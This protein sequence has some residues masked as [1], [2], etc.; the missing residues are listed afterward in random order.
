MILAL[1]GCIGC[2][3]IILKLVCPVLEDFP[4][5]VRIFFHIP[6]VCTKCEL[7]CPNPTA[8]G[9]GVYPGKGEGDFRPRS[10][11]ATDADSTASETDNSTICLGNIHQSFGGLLD[12]WTRHLS[13]ELITTNFLPATGQRLVGDGG[14]P[15]D[16]SRNQ[17]FA[18]FPKELLDF[19]RQYF[20]A[21]HLFVEKLYHMGKFIRNV[22]G[23]EKEAHSSRA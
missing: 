22:V 4:E 8:V 19:Y 18:C 20:D 11:T 7:P 9:V 16:N 1:L 2:E 6:S 5:F 13:K 21:R 10:A 14:S 23:D 17:R 3:C 15:T 12:L